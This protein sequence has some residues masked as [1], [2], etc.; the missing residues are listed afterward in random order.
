MTELAWK[1]KGNNRCKFRKNA[2]LGYATCPHLVF[3]FARNIF[4]HE[5]RGCYHVAFV[6]SS[7]FSLL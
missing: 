2:S 3:V 6:G 4:G 5:Y 7:Q 1:K